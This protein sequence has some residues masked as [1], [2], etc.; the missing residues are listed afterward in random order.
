MGRRRERRQ[1]TS[2]RVKLDLTDSEPQE[3]AAADS[4]AG[5]E[6][7]DRS[8]NDG[9]TTTAAAS[10][11]SNSGA[12]ENSLSLLGQYDADDDGKV[13]SEEKTSSG[14]IDE[15]KMD[16]EVADFIA[17]LETSG[18]LDANPS[19]TSEP[20]A[21]QV[22]EP[23]TEAAEIRSVVE[24]TSRPSLAS[25]IGDVVEKV[26]AENESEKCDWRAVLHEESGEYY[27][28]NV[29]TGETTWNKHDGSVEAAVG[30][31]PLPSESYPGLQ[32]TYAPAICDV[33]YSGLV[34]TS[35]D[36][37]TRLGSAALVQLG[38]TI[39]ER[40]K[41]LC[42]DALVTLPNRIRLAVEAE[43]R[44]SDCRLLMA[45]G[46][47]DGLMWTNTEAHIRRIESLLVAEQQEQEAGVRAEDEDVDMEVDM[48]IEEPEM[49]QQAV[50]PPDE[51]S[52]PPPPPEPEIIPPPP[53]QEPL[54][55][56]TTNRDAVPPRGEME[57]ST[58]ASSAA[59]VEA[60]AAAAKKASK[61]TRMKKG[62]APVLVSKTS[63][64]SSLVNK[65]MAAKQELH[66]SD[67]E[68][69]EKELYD[70]EAIERK[71]QREI[72]DWR[73]EQIASGQA[74]DNVN[75]QPLGPID[76]R[77]R[78][79]RARKEGQSKVSSTSKKHPNLDVLS[80]GLAP[81]WKAFYD[82]KSGDVYYGN[83]ETSET[84]WDRPVA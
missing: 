48:D 61:A 21:K 64:M 26:L 12:P 22:V 9:D 51:D 76:W 82:E 31:A 39:C 23:T 65:W 71:R 69:G 33:N 30:V 11:P 25:M 70:H 32:A 52:A 45:Q 20:E 19:E 66:E 29:V 4:K 3:N 79:K 59:L 16:A 56:L 74:L 7:A 80:K 34:G 62:N 78:V 15:K 14:N 67:D 55:D 77:D 63:K 60:A 46:M 40:L 35:D 1:G 54:S 10:P 72:D 8:R 81:G 36:A 41:G 47:T 28:W 24:R 75:F 84:T 42:G 53:A 57:T 50:P 2:R 68:D 6:I 49:I 17:E 5:E 43:I 27:Y 38:E 37:D 73:R 44:L 83:L 13:E 58:S 18:L